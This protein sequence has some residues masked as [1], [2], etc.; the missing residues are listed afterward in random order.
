MFPVVLRSE[1]H[2]DFV[3]SFF[4]R[5]IGCTSKIVSPK[6]QGDEVNF[7]RHDWEVLMSHL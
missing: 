6:K 5:A 1:A 2:F 3:Q 7:P 4:A